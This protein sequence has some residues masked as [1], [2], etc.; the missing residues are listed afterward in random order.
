MQPLS[1][2][3]ACLVVAYTCVASVAVA[4]PPSEA[5][6]SV[7]DTARA[8]TQ[9]ASPAPAFRFLRNLDQRGLALQ[10]YDAVAFF[11]EGKAVK[12]SSEFL[13]QHQGATYL[14]ASDAHL[15]LFKQDPARYEP[16]FGGYCAYGVSQGHL[17]PVQI[18]TWQ[19]QAGRLLLNYDGGIRRRFDKDRERL[20]SKADHNWPEIVAKKGK[21]LARKQSSG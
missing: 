17:A 13:L 15:E 16:A 6:H 18:D 12:G 11:T 1:R 19:I 14:F 2:R 3:A 5:T 21:P 8:A 7:P 10:G 9:P 4:T 20:L